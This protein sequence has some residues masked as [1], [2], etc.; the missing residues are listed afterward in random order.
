MLKN[1]LPPPTPSGADIPVR[2]WSETGP[3]VVV[4]HGGPGAP[5]SAA[6]IA[7]GLADGFRALEPWQ[8]GAEETPL[9]V[10]RHIVDLSRVLESQCPGERPAL[11]GES[12]GAMLALAFAA[13]H[14][15]AVSAIALV[16]CGTFDAAS[17]FRMHEIL[18][19]RIDEDRR[20][21]LRTIQEEITDP[22]E[23]LR[24]QFSLIQPLYSWD[25]IDPEPDSFRHFDAQAHRESWDDLI[26]LQESGRYPAAFFAIPCPVAMFHGDYDPHPG[27][28]IRDGLRPYLP[29][30]E[31][32]E[33]QHS[34]HF[35]WNEREATPDFFAELCQWLRE[36][37]AD[38]G[39]RES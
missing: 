16:G 8:R 31:Y 17:R 20:R 32:R 25:P 4:L 14:P 27:R 26:R 35:L 13:E 10:A 34:G 18:A 37:T 28:M 29:R 9:T 3:T 24:K 21:Q 30:L 12:W 22:D 1:R 6:P 7:R 5:G 33:F 11:V 23:R 19:E 39:R 2:T 36:R 38:G 15:G